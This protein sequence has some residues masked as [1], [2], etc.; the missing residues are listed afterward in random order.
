MV[1]CSHPTLVLLVLAL[2]LGCTPPEPGST[3]AVPAPNLAAF[4][5]AAREHIEGEQREMAERLARGEKGA[6]L[7]AA[8]GELGMIYQ[9]Y[10]LDEPAAACHREARRLDPVDD[11]WTYYLAH[12]HRKKGELEEA[13]RLLGEV[14][15]KRPH[16]VPSLIWRASLEHKLG[17][18]AEAEPLLEHALSIEPQNP[19]AHFIKAQIAAQAGRH[20]EA[21]RHAEAALARQPGASSLHLLLATSYARLGDSAKAERHRAAGGQQAPAFQDPWLQ[22]LR[23]LSVG[24]RSHLIRGSQAMQNGQLGMAIEEF[25]QA[26]AIAPTDPSAQLNLGAALAQARRFEE[27]IP[28]LEQALALPLE[29]GTRSKA[30]FNLGMLYAMKGDRSRAIALLEAAVAADP[31]NAGA[32][33]QLEALRQDRGER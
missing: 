11:R 29:P 22:A 26:V 4:E 21:V 33:R 15:A 9:A 30:S 19:V 25:R 31:G 1:R 7:G 2:A 6:K 12:L 32:A 10:E 13:S 24:A 18:D 5:P 14:L 17:H 3:L 28:V 27:A 16:D 23:S 20:G 8:W